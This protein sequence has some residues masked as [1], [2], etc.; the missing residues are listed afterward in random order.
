MDALNHLNNA[1]YFRHFE[2]A[3]IKFFEE[4]GIWKLWEDKVMGPVLKDCYAKYIRPVTFPDKLTIEITLSE[5]ESDRFTMNYT[6]HS[7]AQNRTCTVGK[8]IIVFIDFK[9][10]KPTSLPK[11]M[12]K[13]I[14]S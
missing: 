6:A 3:R 9:S 13:T 1:V 7:E 5:I 10:G 12:L 4:L 8:S 2:T 11:E 14:E